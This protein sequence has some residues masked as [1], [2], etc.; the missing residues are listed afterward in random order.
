M[1]QLF[2][3]LAICLVY[4][5]GVLAQ[6]PVTRQ[7]KTLNEKLD[8]LDVY[9]DSLLDESASDSAEKV[10][11]YALSIIP[12]DDIKHLS[13]FYAHLGSACEGSTMPET[14]CINRY[15]TAQYYAEKLG[16]LMAVV[17]NT[18]SMMNLYASLRGDTPV[19]SRDSLFKELVHIKD[20]TKDEPVLAKAL[21]Y[22]QGYYTLMGKSDSALDYS[23]KGAE[24]AKKLYSQGKVS[25][26]FVANSIYRVVRA[27]LNNG[28]HEKQLQYT[29]EMRN[30][31]QNNNSFLA[32]AYMFI[33]Q[34]YI[35]AQQPAK[36]LLY[37]DSLNA[38][39]LKVNNSAT[40]NNMLELN[41]YFAQAFA[42][43]KYNQPD[44]AYIYAKRALEINEKW[45]YEYY[46]SNVNYSMGNALLGLKRYTDAM[47]YL[48]KGAQYSKA[49]Y[50]ELYLA[51]L[52]KIS[53][54]YAGTGNLQMA[55]NYLDT[56]ANVQDSLSKIKSDKAFADAEA[57]YQTKE[58]QQQ[59]ELK[60]VQLASEKKQR[61]WLVA[62][63]V[64]VGTV[65]VLLVVIY[66]NK[67][68]SAKTLA[69]KN[70][71][72]AK[73]IKA[74]EEANQ[75]KARLFSIIS[76]DLRSPI[77]Q[78]YQFLKLQQL[79]PG[80]LNEN[81]RAELSNKI[82]TATGT[83]LE[84]MED[85]LIWS[86]TQMNQFNIELQNTFVT[87]IVDQC[88]SLLHLN[89]EAKNIKVISS[90]P[91]NLRIETD[92]YFLQTIL[93]NLLQ[94]AIKACPPNL[95]VTI[96]YETGNAGHIIYIQ[97]PGPLFTQQQYERLLATEETGKSLSGLGLRLVNEL[98]G[99][100]GIR[101]NYTQ[102]AD[103]QTRVQLALP[104][105]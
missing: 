54:A 67:R 52:R 44:K 76:H 40:W 29:F 102:T 10:A 25:S 14:T 73:L 51:C 47:P 86:K 8:A 39:T 45:G 87:A 74:L 58:K 55:Y 42:S 103:D 19:V 12:K 93:R 6:S 11:N 32:M 43:K 37:Y 3:L 61:L 38:L 15:K 17:D 99:K 94:N 64:L 57:Q 62:G 105:R 24:L 85:L 80:M 97:N 48:L 101:V 18:A 53:V 50:G 28:N 2:T 33:A 75:T 63:L 69:E 1:K 22:I 68:R 79:N 59:I 83:L 71:A 82:Q 27:F 92:P 5:T 81:Q 96:G 31:L 34:D 77:N 26:N 49:L 30:Y 46:T 41:F 35:R 88:I 36:A 70:T 16:D 91:G 98:S 60:N 13:Q 23:L 95:T 90:L 9:C 65:A 4:S 84:T 72:L 104:G 21:G 89:S 56:F 20:T 66:A 7:Y 78:V 100:I